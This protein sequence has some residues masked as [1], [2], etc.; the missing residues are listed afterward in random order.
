MRRTRPERL[1][2][3][4]LAAMCSIAA[5]VLGCGGGG[6][7]SDDPRN[8]MPPDPGGPTDPDEPTD[9][10]DPAAPDAIPVGSRFRF[11][12]STTT[13]PGQP[14]EVFDWTTTDTDRGDYETNRGAPGSFTFTY[15]PTGDTSATFEVTYISGVH[16]GATDTIDITFTDEDSGTYTSVFVPPPM[17]RGPIS[18]SSSG[19]FGADIP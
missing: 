13:T 10:Q 17:G 4:A 18:L 12:A 9:P 19:A 15:A 6:G 1:S 16:N 11:E 7:S 2:F 5:F 14:P 3:V 8:P